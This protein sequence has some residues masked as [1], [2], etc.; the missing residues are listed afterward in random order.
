ML[1]VLV[2]IVSSFGSLPTQQFVL[3][4]PISKQECAARLRTT[5]DVRRLLLVPDELQLQIVCKPSNEKGT[6]APGTE[7]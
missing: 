3:S 2:V 5:N 6:P 4:Q 7:A 1:Y